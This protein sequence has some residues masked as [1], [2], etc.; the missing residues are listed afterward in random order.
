MRDLLQLDEFRISQ[1]MTGGL[2]KKGHDNQL[3]EAYNIEIGKYISDKVM[4]SYTQGINHPLRRYSL[5]Y[6]FNDRFSAILGRNENNHTW[7]GIESRIS[8]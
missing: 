5:R 8:F 1:D 2:E 3:Q 4:I 7:V 6:D